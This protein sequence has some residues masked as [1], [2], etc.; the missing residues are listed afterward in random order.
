M[1]MLLNCDTVYEPVLSV[2]GGGILRT[3]GSCGLMLFALVA[4]LVA[5]SPVGAVAGYGDVDDDRYFTEPVQWSV[6]NDITAID[7]T[8]FSPDEPVSRGETALYLWNMEGRPEPS[9]WHSFED[10]TR[11]TPDK[12]ISWMFEAGVTTGTS[13][14]T[15]S[16]WDKLSRGQIAAFLWRLAGEPSAAAH[17]FV[18]VQASWQQDAVSWLSQTGITNGTAPAT[19][20]PDNA[21]TRKELIT[22]LWRNKGKPA[23]TVDPDSPECNPGNFTAVTAGGDHS[24]GLRTNNTITCWGWNEHGQSDAPAG[25]FT[26]V[27]AGGTH[28]C[29]LRSDR[30]ITCW[31]N[32]DDGKTDAPAGSFEAVTAGTRHSCGL[33]SD[34]TITC[35]GNNH[36]GQADA[37][38]GSFTA[39][40]AGGTHS[41]GLR[42]DTTI[43]C[44]GATQTGEPAPTGSFTAVTAGADH[45]CGLRSDTT[46][47]CWGNNEWGQADAPAGEYVTVRAGIWHT[48]AIRESGEIACW[49]GPDVPAVLR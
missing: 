30:T 43:T 3:V 19:F 9:V 2:W 18:D 7:G 28:S 39:V 44:W 20:S 11:Y 21:L 29:G 27:T 38:T 22:F 33:R 25:S 40:T 37:P 6:D 36:L 14:T 12:A 41:C 26:A 1:C 45:S 31:G 10:S 17:P 32:Y 42:S 35:W 8:C 16:P 23:V 47:T 15:F 48:C 13:P 46:I 5:A 24:C 34:T 4:S 49:G